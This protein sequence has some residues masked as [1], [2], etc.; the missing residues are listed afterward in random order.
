MNTVSKVL[1]EYPIIA[2]VKDDKFS[3]A[4]V[5][6]AGVIFYL[7]ADLLSVKE[8][9][10]QAHQSGKLILVHL[11]LAIGIGKD[12]SGLKYLKQCGIDGVIS[13]RANLIRTAKEQGLFTVQRFF[14]LD[15]Q[16]VAG[17]DGILENSR[18]DMIEIMPGVVTR[19]IE[20]LSHKGNSVIAGGLIETKSDITE[21]LKAGA[22]AISTGKA[23]LWSV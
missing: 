21:A 4:I 5:S 3:Q 22:F 6:P 14:A 20:R 2:A 10:V 15:S 8:R 1:D 19:V 17:I 12:E 13:T 18:P 7:S 9:T 11:D 16:G 23:E